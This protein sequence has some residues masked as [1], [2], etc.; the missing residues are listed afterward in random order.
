MLANTITINNE[1]NAEKRVRHEKQYKMKSYDSKILQ[2]A[3]S[4]GLPSTTCDK[5]AIQISNRLRKRDHSTK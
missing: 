5:V 4:K 3:E 1:T 2:A